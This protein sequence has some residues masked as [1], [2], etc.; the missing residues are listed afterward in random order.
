MA[1]LTKS[2]TNGFGREIGRSAARTLLNPVLKGRDGN[3]VNLNG[4]SGR[5]SKSPNVDILDENIVRTGEL[6]T[7]GKAIGN[8]FLCMLWLAL[9]ITAP[10]GIIRLFKMGF[11]VRKSLMVHALDRP[12]LKPDGRTTTGF[13]VDEQ[14]NIV[15]SEVV[16]SPSRKLAP[17]FFI[18]GAISLIIA[19]TMIANFV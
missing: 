14:A 8:Y 7:V 13:R 12:Y 2:I 16:K 17:L 9:V 11:K 4:G 15:D 6:I 1:T 10:F 19:I 3:Y 5:K 18:T